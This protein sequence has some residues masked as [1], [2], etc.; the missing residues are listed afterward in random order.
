MIIRVG[1][2]L[3]ALVV[4]LQW[5]VVNDFVSRTY[6][7]SFDGTAKITAGSK[8]TV[9]FLVGSVAA[10]SFAAYAYDK[11]HRQTSK[12]RYLALITALG[13]LAGL[14][15]FSGLVVSGVMPVTSR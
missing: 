13:G 8:G 2:G 10:I 7:N 5:L 14:L 12:L 3:A 9:L 6:E 11:L 4:A 1:T 15:V